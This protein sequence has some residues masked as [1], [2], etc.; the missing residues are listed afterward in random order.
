[1]NAALAAAAGLPIGYVKI[2]GPGPL[3]LPTNIVHF[4]NT[5]EPVRALVHEFTDILLT[6]E[7]QRMAGSAPIFFGTVRQG[8]DVPAEAKPYVPA[9]AAELASTTSLDWPK[10]A[11]LRGKT[12]ETF[13]RMFAG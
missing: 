3:M 10:V 1:V 2:A 6:E 13:D 11:P 12:V 5:A 8:L 4:V 7:I 9:T